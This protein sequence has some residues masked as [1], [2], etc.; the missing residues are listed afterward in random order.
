MLDYYDNRLA[1]DSRLLQSPA[2]WP[3]TE[4][5]ELPDDLREVTLDLLSMALEIGRAHV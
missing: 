3:E 4:L 5:A 1:P 2:V